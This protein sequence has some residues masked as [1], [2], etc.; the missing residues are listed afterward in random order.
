MEKRNPRF[1]EIAYIADVAQ[2]RLRNWIERKQITLDASTTEGIH[3]RFTLY[4]ALKIA[5][6]ALL[7]KYG[8]NIELANVEV[9]ELFKTAGYVR[10]RGGID[11]SKERDT[12]KLLRAFKNETWVWHSSPTEEHGTAWLRFR[13]DKE[14][15]QLG[16]GV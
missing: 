16:A 7:T 15:P 2:F 9:D 14:K 13:F 10:A 12:K 4:D 11:V 8:M 1:A 6:V 5:F 3:R